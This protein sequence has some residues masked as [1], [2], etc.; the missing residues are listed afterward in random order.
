MISPRKSLLFF[1]HATLVEI[2][3]GLKS[4]QKIN[5]PE[6][7][8]QSYGVAKKAKKIEARLKSLKSRSTEKLFGLYD[9]YIDFLA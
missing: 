2:R 4:W 1:T 8:F 9:I 5:K 3:I 7:H 6:N